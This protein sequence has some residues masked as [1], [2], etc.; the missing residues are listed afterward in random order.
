MANL[1][2]TMLAKADMDLR[3]AVAAYGSQ[4][5][6]A[7]AENFHVNQKIARVQALMEKYRDEKRYD[8]ADAIR[9]ALNGEV[10]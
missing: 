8:V 5:S 2:D 3:E 4:L 7:Q 9:E 10:E 6:W 1:I